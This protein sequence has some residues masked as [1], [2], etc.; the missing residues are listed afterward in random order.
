MNNVAFVG[1][2]GPHP[3]H[4][5]LPPATHYATPWFPSPNFPDIFQEGVGRDLVL[6]IEGG[7]SSD[8]LDALRQA[9]SHPAQN[10]LYLI[11][12]AERID[13]VSTRWITPFP[14]SLTVFTLP[15]PHFSEVRYAAL[16]RVAKAI[17][18]QVGGQQDQA[19]TSIREII[20][21]GFLLVDE[22]PTLIDNLVGVVVAN[23]GGDALEGLY[24]VQSRDGELGDPPVGSRVFG[25]RGSRC[26]IGPD[27]GGHPHDSQGH[28]RHRG[29]RGRP[30]WPEVGVPGH[31]QHAG[32]VHQ[33]PENGLRAR[34]DV[35][36]VARSSPGV[37]RPAP[38][39]WSTLRAGQF[40]GV[41]RSSGARHPRPSHDGDVGEPDSTG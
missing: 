18:E 8:E 19:E 6:Q 29:E 35:S 32:T 10:D 41:R 40:Q 15:F 27:G 38:G 25:E 13:M 4:L 12:R 9:A 28:P 31:L 26:T 3:E 20:S 34:R 23:I 16:A 37:P 11:T 22:G 17:V 33:P 30:A 2:A 1:S 39:G 5:E 24:E 14:D 36:G 21:A 7:F